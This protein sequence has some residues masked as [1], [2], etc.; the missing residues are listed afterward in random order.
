MQNINRRQLLASGGA[1]LGATVANPFSSLTSSA[2][3][4]IDTEKSF[5]LVRADK[6]EN[7]YGHKDSHFYLLERDQSFS[8]CLSQLEL[9]W[10]M[11]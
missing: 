11:S 10:L 4:A 2:L 9:N 6:N 1:I 5:D 7:P 8:L 3:A